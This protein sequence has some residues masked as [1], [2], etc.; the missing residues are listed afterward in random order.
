MN[1]DEIK[2]I[3]AEIPAELHKQVKSACAD[4]DVQIRVA[5]EQGLRLWLETTKGVKA[6]APID[7]RTLS[8][9]ERF[10]TKRK[11]EGDDDILIVLKRALEKR[12][13]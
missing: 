10:F 11:N 12:Y 13:S 3:N 1:D 6:K 9:L 5:V 4:L 2:Q 7:Y 8:A